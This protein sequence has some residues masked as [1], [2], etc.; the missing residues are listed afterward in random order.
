M[1]TAFFNRQAGGIRTGNGYGA[2]DGSGDEPIHEA[3]V[4]AR[5]HPVYAHLIGADHLCGDGR[6]T[7][8]AT[9]RE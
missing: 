7:G 2:T 9:V 8:R 4:C 6:T 1:K 3:D 5:F